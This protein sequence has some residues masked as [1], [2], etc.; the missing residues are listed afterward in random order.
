MSTIPSALTLEEVQH[1]FRTMQTS[2]DR[3]GN[4]SVKSTSLRG[5]RTTNAG[6]SVAPSDY[7]TQREVL[8]QVASLKTYVDTQLKTKIAAVAATVAATPGSP[9]GPPVVQPPPSGPPT[10]GV[11]T[12]GFDLSTATI[13]NSPADIATW[14]VTGTISS[15][16]ILPGQGVY[17]FCNKVSPQNASAPPAAGE[18]PQ[19]PV[20]YPD[21]IG[22]QYTVWVL[23]QISGTWYAS[24]FVQ[25]WLGRPGTGAIPSGN[26]FATNWA[27]S[28]RW[29]PM[30]GY[31][32]AVGEQ[33]GIFVSAGNARGF[34]GVS[35]VKERS[36]VVQLNLPDVNGA[37]FA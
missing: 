7:T 24:G 6:D 3:I 34:T 21:A 32:P 12:R 27:Y 5:N 36:E 23:V 22:L 25:M 14:P 2:I 37:V 13:E 20:I 18:W 33:I 30:N 31:M 10:T 16:S 11:L 35:T 9:T 29:G 15:V 1:A 26:D 17:V 8:A 19:D 4:Q 28:S